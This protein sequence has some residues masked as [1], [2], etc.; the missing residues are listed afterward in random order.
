MLNSGDVDHVG[1]YVA[2]LPEVARW[3]GAA[4]RYGPVAQYQLLA[5]Q[6]FQASTGLP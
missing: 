6:K 2:A 3:F 4:A 1:S 5:C